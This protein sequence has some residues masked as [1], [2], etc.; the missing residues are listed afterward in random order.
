MCRPDPTPKTHAMGNPGPQRKE[1]EDKMHDVEEGVASLLF[2]EETL[3]THDLS[4]FAGY[5]PG[6]H[7]LSEED[8]Q[9]GVDPVDECPDQCLLLGDDFAVQRRPVGEVAGEESG[10]EETVYEAEEEE[11]E[12]GCDIVQPGVGQAG[13]VHFLGLVSI[14]EVGVRVIGRF[15]FL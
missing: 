12:E 7:G 9:S 11:S 4:P 3:G 2:F 8:E 6:E 15:P 5:V 10:P 13:R 1:Q 14:R